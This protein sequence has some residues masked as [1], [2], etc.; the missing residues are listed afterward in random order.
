MADRRVEE[1][2]QRPE[3]GDR[4]DR[5][6]DLAGTGADD[7]RGRDD[8]RVAADGRSDRD[9]HG[10]PVIDPD[11]ARHEQDDRERSSH[12]DD[13]Q[14]RRRQPDPGDL[15]QAQPRPEQDDPEPQDA[16]GAEREARCRAPPRR[17]PAIAATTI[18]RRRA[19]ETSA[20]IDGQ[21]PGDEPGNERDRDRRREPGS[22]RSR[23][24]PDRGR[25][26]VRT[27]PASA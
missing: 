17:G 25:A 23:A 21:E 22:D 1:D 7:R 16:L 11:E 5:V 2:R 4:R 20:T 27:V 19:T 3:Q 6:G 13:D 15:A 12:R 9:E 8:R 24:T 18:P 10:Q 14:S 26:D